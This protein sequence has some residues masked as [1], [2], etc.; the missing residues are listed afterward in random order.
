MEKR[1]EFPRGKQKEFLR[2]SRLEINLPWSSMAKKLRIKAGT[3]RVAYNYEYCRLPDKVFKDICKLRR[4]DQKRI[5]KEFKAKVVEYDPR[6]IIGRKAW[7]ETRVKLSDVKIKF[8]GEPEK[9]EN[10]KIIVSSVDNKKKLKFPKK[11]TP[12]LAEEIGIHLG[13]GFFSNK[14]YEYRL[15][16]NKDEKKYYDNFVKPLYKKLFNLD[17][18]IK[19][20]ET[21]YGFE[22]YS[23]GLWNFKSEILSL[24]SGPK[25]NIKVPQ[26]VKVND[27]RILSSF[28]RGLF[29]T[30]GSVS[31]ISQYGFSRYYPRIT[32]GLKSKELIIGAAEILTMLGLSPRVSRDGENIWVI[33]L[34]G[35]ERLAKYSKLV[36]WSNP[37]HS[38]KV[39][40]WKEQYPKLGKEVI[41]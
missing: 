4:R 32:I 15:K 12:E 20:Y 37:K 34:N 16:G 6:A 7:G 21:T 38:E 26:I 14:K 31:F 27:V 39:K 1:V 5:L 2:S 17:V 3:L 18:N 41:I 24:K 33:S 40:K 29:D 23:K 19:E 10:E 8:C 35:Y 11:L 9:F 30:D 22:L 13:D 36:G 28:V 25:N